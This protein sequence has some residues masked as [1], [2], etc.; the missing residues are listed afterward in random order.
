MLS[1]PALFADYFAGVR[2]RTLAVAAALPEKAMDWAPREGEF[3]AGDILRHLAGAQ[4]MYL[5]AFRGEG[6][7]FPGHA[8]SLAPDKAAA[9]RL[10]EE[11]QRA[12]D[13]DLR[14][15]PAAALRARQPDLAGR[16]LSAWR[17]LMMLVEHEIHH[18][19]Q[20]TG[21]L[22]ALGVAS[23]HLFGVGVE[24]LPT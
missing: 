8:R 2:R 7:H 3:T 15:M 17:I 6:W 22:S 12:F 5:G 1:D 14:V 23:P 4:R 13:A 16:T 24:D 11:R 19:S 20:L 10:L 9:L 18:R 21:Y